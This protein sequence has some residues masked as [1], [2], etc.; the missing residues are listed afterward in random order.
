MI[1]H[2][3]LKEKIVNLGKILLKDQQIEYGKK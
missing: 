1:L 2:L 3:K